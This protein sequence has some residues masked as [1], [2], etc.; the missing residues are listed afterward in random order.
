[1]VGEDDWIAEHQRLVP[2]LSPGDAAAANPD[3]AVCFAA[4]IAAVRQIGAAV[5]AVR[6]ATIAIASARARSTR[7]ADKA[8]P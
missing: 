1:V 7:N 6:F 3:A 4:A 5:A 8:W 2:E